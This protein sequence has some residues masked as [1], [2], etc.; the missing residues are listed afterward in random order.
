MLPPFMPLQARYIEVTVYHD[1]ETD[2]SE[3]V[4]ITPSPDSASPVPAKRQPVGSGDPA[5][6]LLVVFDATASSFCC[7]KQPIENI[8]CGYRS[9]LFRADWP[10]A[11]DA[12]RVAAWVA[13]SKEELRLEAEKISAEDAATA[14]RAGSPPAARRG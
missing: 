6:I 5:D 7:C 9:Q 13:S 14:A 2:I 4:G 12:D 11:E 10:P 1:D 3:V 8:G